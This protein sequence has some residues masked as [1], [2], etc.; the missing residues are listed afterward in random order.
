MFID[1]T[2]AMAEWPSEEVCDHV[3]DKADNVIHD[4]SKY[5][6]ASFDQARKVLANRTKSES[7]WKWIIINLIFTLL[8]YS[9]M[10]V[11]DFHFWIYCVLYF[12][13]MCRS[14]KIF[15]Y[16]YILILLFAFKIFISV[17][18]DWH[19]FL[20]ITNNFLFLWTE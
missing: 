10:Y 14:H 9:G 20:S 15:W 12:I 13:F 11:S 8:F 4:F 1:L 7:C 5:R 19:L 18:L 6:S 17:Y 3:N 16:C 2:A